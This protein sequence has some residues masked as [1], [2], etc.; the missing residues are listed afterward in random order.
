MITNIACGHDRSAKICQIQQKL[1]FFILACVFVVATCSEQSPNSEYLPPNQD[2]GA[3]AAPSNEYLAPAVEEQ[4]AFGSDGYRYRAVHR[5]RHR[6]R[7]DVSELPSAEYLPPNEDFGD[8]SFAA[9]SNEYLAPAADEQFGTELADDG[10]HYK[11][12]RRFRH[13]SR[14]DVSELPSAEYLPPNQ[15]VAAPSNEYLA[16]AEEQTVLA[17]D[18]YRYKTVRKFRTHRK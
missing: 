11:V 15:G 8:Q 10:Y 4:T 3:I 18:G 17:N 2:F 6:H 1:K 7:R 13:R 12:V 5:L 14:R 16:P 9:P